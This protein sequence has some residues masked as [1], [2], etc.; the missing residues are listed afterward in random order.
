VA[1]SCEHGS[2]NGQEYIGQLSG[3]QIH[4]KDSILSGPSLLSVDSAKFSAQPHVS[5]LL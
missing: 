2:I 3:C 4:M 1:S 5:N